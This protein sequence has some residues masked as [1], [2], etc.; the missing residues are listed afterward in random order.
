MLDGSAYAISFDS[1]LWYLRGNKAVRVT[2]LGAASQEMP[3]L[4]EITPV[5]DGSAYATA[6]EHEGGLWYLHAEHAEKVTEAAA[7]AAAAAVP[8]LS[9]SAFYALYMAEHKKRKEAEDRADNPP[10]DDPRDASDPYP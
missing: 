5:L 6:S 1:N 8:R 4:S 3:K 2:V 9:D 7:L 10:V